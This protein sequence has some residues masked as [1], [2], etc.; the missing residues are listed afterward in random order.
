MWRYSVCTQVCVWDKADCL[1]LPLPACVSSLPT[2]STSVH[3]Y[4]LSSYCVP[5]IYLPFSPPVLTSL[6][7]LEHIH[8]FPK[9]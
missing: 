1:S 7:S 6:H 3:K 5:G 4:L 2:S 9:P 8:T